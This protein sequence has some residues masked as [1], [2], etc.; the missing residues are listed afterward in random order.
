[1]IDLFVLLTPHTAPPRSYRRKRSALFSSA[2]RYYFRTPLKRALFIAYKCDTCGR[3]FSVASNL[4]RHVKRCALRPVHGGPTRAPGSAPPTSSA[5]PDPHQPPSSS[6]S[7]G[8][9]LTTTTGTTNATGNTDTSTTVSSSEFRNEFVAV[10]PNL[11]T[12]PSARSNKR[13]RTSS[14]SDPASPS[15]TSS[16]QLASTEPQPPK[17]RRRRRVPQPTLWIPESLK[18]FDFTPLLKP[19]PVPLPPVHPYTDPVTRILYE[20]RDSYNESLNDTE[21]PYHNEG[22]KGVLPGPAIVKPEVG[23]VGG[24]LLVF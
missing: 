5:S 16:S 21:R 12:S 13:R 4:S 1:M 15:G 11:N 7:S 8:T 2:H 22:W 10:Q 23:C 14:T 18:L 3:R 24:T 6:S 17:P 20:E 9:S 19:T